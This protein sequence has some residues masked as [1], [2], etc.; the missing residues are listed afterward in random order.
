[1]AAAVTGALFLKISSAVRFSSY[2]ATSNNTFGNNYGELGFDASRSSK[3]Y[4]AAETVQ[5]PAIN[6]IIQVRF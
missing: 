1:M 5:P 3:I 6:A 2:Y 4:G